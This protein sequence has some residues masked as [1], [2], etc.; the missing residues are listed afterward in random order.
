MALACFRMLIHELLNKD[1]DIIPEGTP[2][3][4]LYRKSDVCMANKGED[5]KHIRHISRRV[6]FV[7][8]GE[9]LTLHKIDWCEFGLQLEYIATKTVGENDLNTRMKY[10]TV[11]LDN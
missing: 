7:R 8:N 1:L 11:S 3:I 5:T 6:N 9:K 2:L 4:I 10:I